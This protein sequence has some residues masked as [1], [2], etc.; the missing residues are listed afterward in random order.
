MI[1]G[2][3]RPGRINRTS[4]QLPNSLSGVPESR[5]GQRSIFVPVQEHM[6]AS[7]IHMSAEQDGQQQEA[8]MVILGGR[9]MGSAAGPNPSPQWR[10]LPSIFLPPSWSGG[11][12]HAP[13][14]L[15]PRCT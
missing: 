4:S 3:A 11:S 1:V 7:A 5:F 2:I 6:S 13:L 9:M 10:L 14:A 15:C 12:M 8:A